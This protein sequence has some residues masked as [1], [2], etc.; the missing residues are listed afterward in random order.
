[1]SISRVNGLPLDDLAVVL[2]QEAEKYQQLLTLLRLE[3]G[4][5]TTG[6]LQALAELVKQGETH[7]LE[8]KV[9]EEARLALLG[10]IST[11]AGVPLAELTLQGLIDHVAPAYA[12]RF[13]ALRERLTVLVTQ[14]G[15]ENEV[16]RALLGR[17]VACMQDSLSLMTTVMGSV[18]IYQGD[19]KIIAQPGSL[20]I[21]NGQA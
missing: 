12:Q 20:E 7:V 15:T 6:N 9:I 13:Q 8:L 17:G 21:L 5:I 18:P 1:M 4:L 16:N 2:E 11:E 3:R 14:L 19:G 10:R